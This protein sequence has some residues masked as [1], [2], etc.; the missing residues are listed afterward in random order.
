MIK[1]IY[2]QLSKSLK[3]AGIQVREETQPNMNHRFASD[4]IQGKTNEDVAHRSAHPNA[5]YFLSS[6]HV[7]SHTL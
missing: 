6:Y 5:Q 3:P 7:L 2:T 1:N 4:P